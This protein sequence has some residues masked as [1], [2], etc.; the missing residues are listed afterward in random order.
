MLDIAKSYGDDCLV[1]LLSDG[2]LKKLLQ[3]HNIPVQLLANQAIAV[4][5][6]SSLIQAL[7]NVGKLAPLIAKVV[8]ISINYDLIYANTQKALVVGAIASFIS[9]RPLVYHLHDIISPEHFSESNRKIIVTLANRFASL[10]IANSLA[11]QSAF[12][13][14]GG[15]TE[16]TKTIY[17]GFETNLYH[18][19]NFNINKI[20]QE[21]GIN[22]QFLVG[23]FSR[24]SPWKGQHILIEALTHC[25]E[26]VTAILVGDALFGEEGYAKLLHQK[27]AQLELEKRVKFLGFRSDIPSLMTACDLIVHTSTAPEPFGRVIVEAMLCGK[28]VVATKAGGAVELI[29]TNKTGWL[30][31]PGDPIKLANAIA[32]CR[33]QPDLAAS[34]A[35]Q[36]R[37]SASQR[38]N[39]TAINQQINQLL[40][41]LLKP[42]EYSLN[43]RF[44]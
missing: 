22:Q 25:A 28:P 31:A 43:R 17:N 24:L 10:V 2:P 29:E 35:S 30:V 15:R 4:R 3:Q 38:F 8:K 37:E 20:R 19:D 40:S 7:S 18:T 39:L 16:I 11:T 36:G 33:N 32:T 41:G 12:I 1:G 23:N 34:I 26:D 27:V 42:K 21:L 9:R 44:T 5:K 13:A 14:A 6:D